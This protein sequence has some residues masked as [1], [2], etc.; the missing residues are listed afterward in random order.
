MEPAMAAEPATA[1]R[2]G[3]DA[4]LETAPLPAGLF[5]LLVQIPTFSAFR[6]PGFRLLW[7]SQLGNSM[8]IWMD[9]V[10]RMWL[11]YELTG[12]TIDLGLVSAVRV[13]PLLVL[14]PVAGT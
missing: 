3:E 14:S 8:G 5:G 6:F 9:N 12:S 2:T 1:Q 7:A 10:S 4:V 11:M 13:V